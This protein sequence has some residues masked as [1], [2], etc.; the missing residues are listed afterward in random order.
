MK[1]IKYIF[2]LLPFFLLGKIEGQWA[3]NGNH[4]YNTNSGN[5]GIGLNAP[6]SLLH[7][8][9]TMTEPTIYL[10]NPGGSGGATL[11]L[12]GNN[13]GADWKIKAIGTGGFKI[14][15]NSYG[16]DVI[17]IESNS[18]ANAL[19]INQE[20]SVGIGTSTPETSALVDMSSTAKGFLPPRLTYEQIVQ[21]QNPAN[22]LLVFCTTYNKF[23]AYLDETDTWKELLFAGGNLE[24]PFV[25]GAAITINHNQGEVAPV[26]KTITYET[27]TNVPG[28]PLKC[29]IVR[30]L[31]ADYQ[32][33]SVD[34]ASAEAAGWN[35]QFNRKQGYYHSGAGLTPNWTIGTIDE[36]SEWLA[37]NDPCVLELGNGWRLPSLS[38]WANVDATNGWDDWSGP[39]NSPLK[40]HAAG[41]LFANGGTLYDRGSIGYYYSSSQVNNTEGGELVFTNSYC[42]TGAVYKAHARSVRCIR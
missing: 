6:Q 16:L 11:R 19:Y 3:S 39:W 9:K 5:V 30:N 25:C 27:V 42:A 41:Y 17:V 18:A 21:I 33:S 12:S 28:E 38:E 34:D 29:W 31:G 13:T 23:Y 7:I 20:G 22:G 35:W 1:A 26:T 40:L 24:P 15:D 37:G 4:I 36:S 10:H 14:R 2:M 32:A 8:S